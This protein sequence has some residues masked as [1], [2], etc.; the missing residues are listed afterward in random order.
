[1]A[2]VFLDACGHGY[3]L[4]LAGANIVVFAVAAILVVVIGIGGL[5][6]P[7]SFALVFMI[8]AVVGLVSQFVGSDR[9]RVL[10]AVR[11]LA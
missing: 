4:Y 8:L 1:L 5:L 10:I 7:R 9:R 11:Q 6:R 3:G 2:A